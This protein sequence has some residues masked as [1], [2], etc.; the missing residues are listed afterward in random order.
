MFSGFLDS[1]ITSGAIPVAIGVICAALL[2][3]VI[4]RRPARRWAL[5]YGIAAVVGAALGFGIAWYVG[6]VRDAFDLT[7]T[8]ATRTWFAVGVA[9]VAVGATSLWRARRWR[10]PVGVASILLFVLLGGI[11]INATVGEFPTV[12][13]VLG[14]DNPQALHVAA[15]SARKPPSAAEPLWKTWTAP[16]GMPATGKIGTVSIPATASH[17]DARPAIVYLPPAALVAHPPALPVIEF[18]GGQP[19]S[20]ETVIDSGQLPEIMNGFASSHHGLA[21]I[22][23]IPDQLGAPQNNPMC[24]DSGLGNVA[25]Y[26]TTDVPTWIRS[27]L[28]VLSGRANWTIGGFSEGGTCSIQLG[29]K[30]RALFGN[31]ID[32]SGQVAPLNG[33]VAHTIRV[34]FGGSSAAY[35]AGTASA[36]LAA[37]AP[38]TTTDGVFAVGADDA[39]YGPQSVVVEKAARAARMKVHTFVSPGTAHDWYTERYG[40]R[41][42]L[43]VLAVRWGLSE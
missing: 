3:A 19:G 32:I 31:I 40:L 7:L 41:V 11:G 27:H 24:L 8:L 26:L 1:S 28:N 5:A 29:T 20:P 39:K 25:T 33:T 34:G 15:G 36:L 30:Y 17:F 21:P 13:S 38:F 43:P 6:D 37:G 16:A 14:M 42:A 35:R 18:L 23:V 12:A 9:G 4:L 22:V 2:V 10:I